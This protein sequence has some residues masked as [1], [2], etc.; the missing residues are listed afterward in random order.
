M[1]YIELISAAGIGGIIGSLLTTFLQLWLS[2][3]QQITNR[4]FQEKKEAYVGLVS[5]YTELSDSCLKVSYG[6]PEARKNFEYWKIRSELVAPKEIRKNI[7]NIKSYNH[8]ESPEN[9]NCKRDAI[10]K[11]VQEL[12]RKDLDIQL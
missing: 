12:I 7:Q 11:S 1:D 4:N 10:F 5:S 6:T 2:N 9:Y 8:G 3:K